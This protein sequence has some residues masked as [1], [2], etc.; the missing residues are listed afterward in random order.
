MSTVYL[1]ALLIAG[2]KKIVD[3]SFT[4]ILDVR[5]V[6]EGTVGEKPMKTGPLEVP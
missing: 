2:F 5:I 3:H 1:M 4:L 6:I